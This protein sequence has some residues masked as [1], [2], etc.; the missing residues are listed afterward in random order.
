[1]WHANA[2]DLGLYVTDHWNDTRLSELSTVI[3]PVQGIFFPI[4]TL[5]TISSHVATRQA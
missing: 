3:D 5:L 2:S 1:M 4:R